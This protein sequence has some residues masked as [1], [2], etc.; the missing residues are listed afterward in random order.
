MQVAY[1]HT[2]TDPMS[3]FAYRVSQFAFVHSVTLDQ[4]CTKYMVLRKLRRSYKCKGQILKYYHCHRSGNKKR[5]HRK[6]SFISHS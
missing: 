1:D 2:D 5:H 6:T 3:Y 4:I